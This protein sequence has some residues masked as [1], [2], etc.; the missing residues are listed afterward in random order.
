MTDYKELLNYEMTKLLNRKHQQFSNLV[1]QKF[2]N[3][4][5]VYSNWSVSDCYV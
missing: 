4:S 5:V 2:S 1:I 3:S